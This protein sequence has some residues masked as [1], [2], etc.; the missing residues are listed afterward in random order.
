[1]YQRRRALLKFRHVQRVR[2]LKVK[3]DGRARNVEIRVNDAAQIPQG[4]A[5]VGG[6]VRVAQIV[7]KERGKMMP[8]VDAAGDGEIDK[9][10]EGFVRDKTGQRGFALFNMHTA[11]Q[12]KRQ[13]GN[14]KV[15]EGMLPPVTSN[16]R[17]N[18]AKH[19]AVK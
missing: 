1:M 17:F 3:G 13:W 18:G 7:P 19:P 6:C 5:Q 9:E 12:R 11:E 4:N 15:A 16:F 14:H 10:R 8:C 2:R